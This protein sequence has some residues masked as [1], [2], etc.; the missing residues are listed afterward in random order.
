MN[1]L[2]QVTFK[3]LKGLRLGEVDRRKERAW[4][5]SQ[6]LLLRCD[7]EEDPHSS[8]T[9]RDALSQIFV[10]VDHALETYVVLFAG[11]IKS[12]Q[13]DWLSREIM[14]R[15]LELNKEPKIE[16]PHIVY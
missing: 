13:L 5:T 6:Y 15:I 7:D 9:F 12:A 16:P 10:D 1:I 14:L 4:L 11:G 3:K 8:T 2:Q